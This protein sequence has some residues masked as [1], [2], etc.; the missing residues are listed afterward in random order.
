MDVQWRQFP[1]ME[2]SPTH[3]PTPK[4][5]VNIIEI[6]DHWK[7]HAPLLMKWG[8]LRRF[9][10]ISHVLLWIQR[11]QTAWHAADKSFLRGWVN[12]CSKLHCYLI[13]DRAT[14]SPT[15]SKCRPAIFHQSGGKNVHQLRDYDLL[16]LWP[17]ISHGKVLTHCCYFQDFTARTF[18]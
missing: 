9:P 8:N 14:T 11:Q 12:Q 16:K 3:S 18:S 5:A 1:E 13:S 7:L 15:F 10:P 4:D 17:A 2:F 6:G